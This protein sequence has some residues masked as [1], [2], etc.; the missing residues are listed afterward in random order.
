[1]SNALFVKIIE[2]KWEKHEEAATGKLVEASMSSLDKSKNTI[3]DL[4]KG[5]NIITELLKEIKNAVNSIISIQPTEVPPTQAQPI[6]TITTHP[7]S[8]QAAPRIDKGKEIATESDEDPT[9]KLVPA[10]TIVC[11]DPDEE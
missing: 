3:S 6:T 8:S 9:K 2:E 4:Y 5:L 7:E 11:H 10:S 1:M